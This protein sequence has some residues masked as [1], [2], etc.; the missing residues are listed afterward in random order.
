MRESLVVR[1]IVN[2]LMLTSSRRMGLKVFII[3]ILLPVIQ[4]W[5]VSVQ[6]AGA[7]VF[8]WSS[9]HLQVWVVCDF[10]GWGVST[11]SLS[12]QAS[13]FSF[14]L[15][16]ESGLVCRCFSSGWLLSRCLLPDGPGGSGFGYGGFPLPCAHQEADLY[17]AEALGRPPGLFTYF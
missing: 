3:S 4:G 13:R 7:W 9:F 6:G 11:G 8:L 14:R 2:A 1:R 12:C 17:H 5:R 16:R 15:L 10:T